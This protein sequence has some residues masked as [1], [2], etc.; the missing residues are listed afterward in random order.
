MAVLDREYK[1]GSEIGAE[2]QS[3]PAMYT[4][5]REPSSRRTGKQKEAERLWQ[6][7]TSR[8]AERVWHTGK[9]K[10]KASHATV[11]PGAAGPGSYGVAG[12]QHEANS[13]A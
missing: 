5:Q 11:L 13:M 4:V 1:C 12:V 7:A 9:R 2:R 3:G 10:I 8:E 6:P